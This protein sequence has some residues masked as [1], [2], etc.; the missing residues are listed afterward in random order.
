MDDLIAAALHD[1][2]NGL[3]TLGVWLEQASRAT[4]SP[5]LDQA[6]LQAVRINSQLVE[7]LALYREDRGILRLAVADQ[8][9]YDFLDDLKQ[10]WL[11]PP[12]T[13]ITL[14]WPD[15]PP[16]QAWAFDAYQVKLVLFDA[17]RNALRHA[18]SAVSLS[19]ALEP[20]GGL[21]FTVADDG[22]GFPDDP[23][24]L[25]HAMGDSGSGLGLRFA[26]L[27]ASHHATPAGKQGRLEMKN[28]PTGGALFS[29]ILP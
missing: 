5:A 8:D 12:E 20:G 23:S 21:R 19:L 16:I 26:Q 11:P 29:L 22:P 17:L 9:L 10:E 2:K 1:A 4:P 6:R 14:Q 24:Q 28:A 13:A 27:V 15:T 3:N 18:R 7:L 25:G